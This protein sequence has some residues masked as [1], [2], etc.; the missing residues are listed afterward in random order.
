MSIFSRKEN[1][2]D[3]DNRL[4]AVIQKGLRCDIQILESRFKVLESRISNLEKMAET[5]ELKP[6]INEWEACVSK[7]K[8]A[9][10]TSNGNIDDA[11]VMLKSLFLQHKIS[12]DD[13]T[14]LIDTLL[15]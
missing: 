6:D 4:L 13:Y 7:K 3:T 8:E 5:T 15:K 2:M 12:I 11:I 9:A 10:L 14:Q 1:E